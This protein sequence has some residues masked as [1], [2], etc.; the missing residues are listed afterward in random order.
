MQHDADGDRVPEAS[1]AAQLPSWASAVHF[2]A[3][4]AH[5]LSRE[6]PSKQLH[7]CGPGDI[8][9][10]WPAECRSGQKPKH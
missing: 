5:G 3:P 4:N 1:L 7:I 9:N 2:R 6:D 8:S 10:D